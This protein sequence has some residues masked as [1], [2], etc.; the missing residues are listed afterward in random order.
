MCAPFLYCDFIRTSVHTIKS[1]AKLRYC[2]GITGVYH[3]FGNL[4]PGS[5]LNYSEDT[6]AVL[7]GHYKDI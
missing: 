3:R 5:V 2:H 1:L 7:L 4:L 6:A